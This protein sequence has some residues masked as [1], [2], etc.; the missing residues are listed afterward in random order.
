MSAWLQALFGLSAVVAIA[1]L[2]ALMRELAFIGS[3]EQGSG[4]TLQEAD[5]VDV[6]VARTTVAFVAVFLP[7]VVMFLV[8]FRAAYRNL[9]ALGVKGLRFKPGWA[10]GAWFVPILS[11]IRP[12]EI[13]NDIW[14]GSDPSAP[15]EQDGPGTGRPVP[16]ILNWWWGFFLIFVVTDRASGQLP[17]K[18]T[19]AEIE[20]SAKWEI[21]ADAVFLVLTALAFTVVKRISERQKARHD[22]LPIGEHSSL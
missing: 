9:G 8:W 1:Q 17:L 22:A 6:L 18:P 14:R 5:A 12:K 21:A 16:A 4:A 19:L 20:Y 13:T 11:L 15:P 10:V 7:T 2:I 3:I